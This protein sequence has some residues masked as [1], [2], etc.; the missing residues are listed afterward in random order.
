MLLALAV[1]HPDVHLCRY[2]YKHPLLLPYTRRNHHWIEC[3]VVVHEYNAR[4]ENIYSIT[5]IVYFLQ[6]IN[7]G[8]SVASWWVQE[9]AE[10]GTTKGFTAR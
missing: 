6:N 4:S 5:E 2:N 10:Q 3:R 9:R 8:N 1:F 7:F